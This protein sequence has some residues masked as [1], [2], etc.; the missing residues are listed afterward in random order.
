LYLHKHERFVL[1]QTL[2]HD[3]KLFLVLFEDSLRT[4]VIPVDNLSDFLV[5]HVCGDVR[6]LL[7]LGN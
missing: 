7:M 4:I 2:G 3:M 1:H 5:D 6:D